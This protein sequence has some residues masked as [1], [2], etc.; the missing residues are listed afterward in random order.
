MSLREQEASLLHPR[1]S[2]LVAQRGTVPC[3]LTP[4]R[5][6]SGSGPTCF[7]KVT[8]LLQTRFVTLSTSL[9]LPVPR[10]KGVII[11]SLS[12]SFL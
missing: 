5:R 7:R 8:A 6:L 11:L 3:V 2:W 12:G 10:H 1:S 9:H 4:T